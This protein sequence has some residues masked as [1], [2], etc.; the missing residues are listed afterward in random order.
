MA[1][2]LGVKVRS[3]GWWSEGVGSGGSWSQEWVN[4][5][6]CTNNKGSFQ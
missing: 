3:G 6:I 1:H 5:S 2:G 4:N